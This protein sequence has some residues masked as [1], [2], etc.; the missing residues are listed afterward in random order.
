MKSLWS[1]KVMR[2]SERHL[3][4]D[5]EHSWRQFPERHGSSEWSQPPLCESPAGLNGPTYA[6]G[7]RF[8]FKGAWDKLPAAW[9][10]LTWGNSSD[11]WWWFCCPTSPDP[12]PCP[13]EPCWLSK[14]QCPLYACQP[15]TLLKVGYYRKIIFLGAERKCDRG[16]V[17]GVMWWK[18]CS[19]RLQTVWLILKC[20]KSVCE[21]NYFWTLNKSVHKV[22]WRSCKVAPQGGPLSPL[23][24][25]SLRRWKKGEFCSP[26]EK[27]RVSPPQKKRKEKEKFTSF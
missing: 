13:P 19:E 4:G 3:G 16:N 26:E 21:L 9:G 22:L 20:R 2:G 14:I 1:L 7:G 23:Q 18:Q 12:G 5:G 25:R 10:E 27:Y 15:G 8:Y 6:R 11:R 17:G 24:S